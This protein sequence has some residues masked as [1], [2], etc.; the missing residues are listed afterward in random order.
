MEWFITAAFIIP[1]IMFVLFVAPIWVI[2]HYK[3]KTRMQQSLSENER[4]EISELKHLAQQMSKRVETLE[5][6]LD[7]E[8]PGWRDK[9]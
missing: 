9:L 3:A 6:I 7:V 1:S 4:Q 8:T 5:K 2:M